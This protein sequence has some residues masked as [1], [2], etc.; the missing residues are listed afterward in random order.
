MIYGSGNQEGGSIWSWLKGAVKTIHNKVI[1][2]VYRKVIKPVGKFVKKH[3]L[4]SKGLS[5]IPHPYASVGSRVARQVGWGPVRKCKTITPTQVKCI[6]AGY[7]HWLPSGAVSL[8]TARRLG[9]KVLNISPAQVRHM[10]NKYGRW[11]RGGG[12]KLAGGNASGYSQPLL[13]GDLGGNQYFPTTGYYTGRGTSLPGGAGVG[14]AGGRGR[15][16]VRYYKK[17]PVYY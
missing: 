13:R 4:V 11:T 16:K 12:I 14:L 2:P 15:S 3:K 17:K 7:G 10:A 1:K 5:L 6:Q 9:H 8:A